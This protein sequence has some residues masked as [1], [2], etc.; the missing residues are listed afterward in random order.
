MYVLHPNHPPHQVTYNP[1]TETLTYTEVVFTNQ[2]VEWTDGNYPSCGTVHK[3]RL[4]LAGSPSQPAQIWA[5]TVGTFT[6]FLYGA[7]TSEAFS[8]VNDHFGAI[9]WMLST[10]TLLFG[11]G[12]AEYIIRADGPVIYIGDIQIDRQ[13]T[14][15]SNFVQAFQAGDKILYVTRDAT[16]LHA[17]QYDDNAVTWLS[18][19]LSFAS[20]HI[21]NAGVIDMTWE[22][23]PL[24]L[25]WAV[26]ADGTL[27]CMNYNRPMGIIGWH[28][29]DTQG[30][31]LSVANGDQFGK[32]SLIVLVARVDG[33][34]NLEITVSDG[35]QMDSRISVHNDPPS[36]TV[37]GLDPLEGFD[38]QVVADG[39]VHPNRIVVGGQITLQL[40]AEFV[41]VG[42]GYKK[43]IKTLP[44][45]KG[46]QTGSARAFKKRYKDIF[47]QVLGSAVPF[48]NGQQ[49]PI[50]SPC[51]PYGHS[52]TC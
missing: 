25:V 27:A 35:A 43:R 17:M 37:T 4:Y 45:D 20:E 49:A 23:S 26:L 52:R 47:L 36:V 48:I 29:H 3:G 22:Q 34:I 30:K 38:C 10:K 40:E 5:S 6:D 19:E 16:K 24:S 33:S 9:E 12:N 39:A 21:L 13:S 28:P 42:L 11:T 7:A 41:Q 44:L 32:T 14:Y 2:P 46:S 18:E 15:G 31:F 1:V 8:V 51:N 50:R